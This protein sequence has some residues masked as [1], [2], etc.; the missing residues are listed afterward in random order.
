M[1]RSGETCLPE[2]A[3][4]GHKLQHYDYSHELNEEVTLDM[5]A[6]AIIRIIGIS[7]RTGLWTE[8][9]EISLL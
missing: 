6:D 8:F 3:P 4:L 2:S 7:Q 9:C 1:A 5:P